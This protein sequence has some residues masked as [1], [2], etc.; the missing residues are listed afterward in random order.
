[1]L[2]LLNTTIASNTAVTCGGGGIFVPTGSVTLQNSIL[3][4]NV[5]PTLDNCRFT[6]AG[7]D[8]QGQVTSLGNNI[9]GST[10]GCTVTL[11]TKDLT[12]NPGLQSF[13]DSAIPGA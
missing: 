6:Q 8:C 12:G 4:L 3:A 10:L 11:G 5:A 1:S 13:T 7:A 9:I 2:E